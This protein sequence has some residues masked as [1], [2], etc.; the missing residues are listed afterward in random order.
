MKGVKQVPVGR[1]HYKLTKGEEKMTTT[2]KKDLMA[3]KKEI[4]ALSK[5]IEKM[6]VAVDKYEK[7]EKK[8][9][10]KAKT[11]KKAP[12]KKK[13]VKVI[14]AK[15]SVKKKTSKLSAA[16]TVLGYIQK[17][18]KGINTNTL[19]KKTEFNRKKVANIIFKLKQQGKI[20]SPEKGVYV[21]S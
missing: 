2:L 14:S 4:K 12:A 11:V 20:N 17:V 7:T 13:S 21:K 10:A 15:R 19:I 3:V 1:K 9:K 8:T 5:K 6:V 18:K 16:D